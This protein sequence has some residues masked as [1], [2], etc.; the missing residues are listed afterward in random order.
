MAVV[1]PLSLELP[2]KLPVLGCLDRVGLVPLPLERQRVLVELNPFLCNLAV[3]NVPVGLCCGLGLWAATRAG[4]V[5]ATGGYSR[6]LHSMGTRLRLSAAAWAMSPS[7]IL[8]SPSA[9][10]WPTDFVFAPGLSIASG[11]SSPL[12][13]WAAPMI[14]SA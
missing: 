4:V 5:W 6:Y 2:V 11:S 14:A 12:S 3:V 10:L 8:E 1:D 9:M 7:P 13:V